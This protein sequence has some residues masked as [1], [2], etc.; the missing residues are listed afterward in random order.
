V[1]VFFVDIRPWADVLY[2]HSLKCVL[3]IE[4]MFVSSLLPKQCQCIEVCT[5]TKELAA[6]VYIYWHSFTGQ[7]SEYK[8]NKER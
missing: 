2:S 5:I 8:E 3:L 7:R 4:G 6:P 1:Q